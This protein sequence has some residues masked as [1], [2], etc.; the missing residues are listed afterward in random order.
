M[1]LTTCSQIINFQRESNK[2]YGPIIET[3]S[4]ITA[5][6]SCHIWRR[7]STQKSWRQTLFVVEMFMKVAPSTRCLLEA[8]VPRLATI[9]VKVGVD[10]RKPILHD[11]PFY[12]TSLLRWFKHDSTPE[13]TNSKATKP[14]S[15]RGTPHFSVE[16]LFNYF[17]AN[18]NRHGRFIQSSPQLRQRW[19]WIPWHGQHN[20]VLY[21][22]CS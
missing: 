18:S 12:V 7:S 15:Q 6:D 17:R 19:R 20:L 5:L 2:T 13:K 21:P 22:C 3:E 4:K 8:W 9:C 16:C 1:Y 11:L 14:I 10:K